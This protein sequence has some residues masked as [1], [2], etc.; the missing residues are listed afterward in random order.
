V[1]VEVRLK[2]RAEVKATASV[3]LRKVSSD[4]FQKPSARSVA[5][6]GCAGERPGGCDRGA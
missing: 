4:A 6:I 3:N 1:S 2:R 5:E